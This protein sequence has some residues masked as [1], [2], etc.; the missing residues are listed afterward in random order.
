M[1]KVR[2]LICLVSLVLTFSVAMAQQK[3]L[4]F[5][6]GA[7]ALPGALNVAAD[8][9][10]F[11][12]EGVNAKV[13]TYKKGKIAFDSY[14]KGKDDIATTN[15]ISIVLTDFDITKHRII[16]SVSYTDNQT[17]ILVR[18]S[19]GITRAADLAGRKIATVRATSGHF[20]LSKFLE[21]NGL[22]ADDVEVVLLTNKE[23]PQALAKGEVDAIC[24]HGM[25]VEKAKKA[26][27][28]DWIMFQDNS[29]HRISV[30]LI[31][32]VKRLQGQPDQVRGVLKAVLKADEFIKAHP[33][34]SVR[35]IAKGK[36][37]PIDVMREA[38]VDETDYN[39]SLKQSLFL[40]LETIENWAIKNR[41]VKRT[42]PRDY[43]DFI[44]F[45]PLEDVAPDKVTVIR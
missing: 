10:Y 30:Q 12:E 11:A 15:I 38:V 43:M 33:E 25:P 14:L 1:P 35:I 20:Y 13:N 45:H 19:S 32:S 37:Y 9:G 24:Q 29:I 4:N 17:K 2:M 28:G 40:A 36:G 23:L 3:P 6:A 26:L 27:K 16:G 18:K 21:I 8:K 42:I 31:A 22:S 44:D 39:L 34:E 5:S 7:G 41:L